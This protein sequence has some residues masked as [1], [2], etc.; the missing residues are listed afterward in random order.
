[1]VDVPSA[2]DALVNFFITHYVIFEATKRGEIDGRVKLMKLLQ[3]AEEELTKKGMR[4]PSFV[5]YKWEHGA[6]SPEAQLDLELLTNSGLVSEDKERHQINPTKDG[7]ELITA[8]REIIEKN[9]ELLEIVNRTLASHVSYRS[10]QLKTLTYG[11]PS[12]EG[13]RKLIGDIAKGEVVLRPVEESKASKF[14]LVDDDWLDKLSMIASKEFRDLVNEVQEK[15][16]LTQYV[17][18]SSLRREYGLD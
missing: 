16:D 11:T 4:G 7:I 13:D 14:F 1:M 12:L 2:K 15:P 5:F 8:S 17:P 3:K 9:R 18:L 10:W 6:W